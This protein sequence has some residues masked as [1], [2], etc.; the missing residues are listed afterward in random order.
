[1]AKIDLEKY[2]AAWRQVPAPG[3]RVLS[4][5]ELHAIMRSTSGNILGQFKKGLVFDLVFKGLL[6]LGLL[7]L[8]YFMP[9]SGA[10]TI[11]GSLIALFLLVGLAWQLNIFR[12][13]P[14]PDP[15]VE[16]TLDLLRQ[17]LAFY[18][19]YYFRSLFV[20]A[21][22]GVFLFLIGALYYYFFKYQ[23]LPR[24]EVEDMLVLGTF[25]ILNFVLSATVQVKQANFHMQQL[26]QRIAEIEERTLSTQALDKQRRAKTRNY[27]LIGLAGIVGLLLL[28]YLIYLP[29]NF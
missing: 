4:E 24:L 16:P 11:S 14:Q 13:I 10:W 12:R 6:L 23:G 7:I 17:Y 22:S 27:V 5:E 25:L 28:L 9:H 21:F 1:M 3:Q 26:E 2:K 19:R 15:G 29:S 20:S 18:H 8:S